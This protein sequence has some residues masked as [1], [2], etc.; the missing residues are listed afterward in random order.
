[1]SLC[2]AIFLKLKN[3]SRWGKRISI[4]TTFNVVQNKYIYNL[5]RNTCNG[6]KIK[7]KI[8]FNGPS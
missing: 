8:S 1:M 4:A 3:S 6:N 2:K 5:V 7:F